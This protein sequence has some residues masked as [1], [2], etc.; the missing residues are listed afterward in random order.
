MKDFPRPM[1]GRKKIAQEAV[2]KP[3]ETV[4]KLNLPKLNLPK[5][6]LTKDEDDGE[7]QS[8]TLQT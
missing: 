6:K 5:F 4:V 1:I 3:V 7:S 8:N 2:D